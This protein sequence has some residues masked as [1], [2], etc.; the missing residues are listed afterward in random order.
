MLEQ[1]IFRTV[2]D[3]T[4]EHENE[5]SEE[6]Y[7]A[8]LSVIKSYGNDAI[9]DELTLQ[10]TLVEIVKNPKSTRLGGSTKAIIQ[11][12][13]IF[14]LFDF[15]V[16]YLT[17]RTQRPGLFEGME[18]IKSTDEGIKHID[19][20]TFDDYKFL[21][22]PFMHGHRLFFR[23]L[24]WDDFVD[25]PMKYN[26]KGDQI[27][28]NGSDGKYAYANL[29]SDDHLTIKGLSQMEEK[30]YLG[31]KL[32]FDIAL[33]VNTISVFKVISDFLDEPRG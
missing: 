29:I 7:G 1:T 27:L 21:E 32:E 25:D 14:S 4:D 11:A 31:G 16:E 3:V 23:G 8:I 24:L 18:Y 33:K 9:E 12:F 22:N 20:V 19:E 13:D 10:Q 30:W 26:L 6:F 5:N 17:L 2:L 28:L 15:L